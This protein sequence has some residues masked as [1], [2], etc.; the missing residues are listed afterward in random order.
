MLVIQAFPTQMI[1]G[2]LM[3]RTEVPTAAG[4][5]ASRLNAAVFG[6]LAG[7]GGLVHGI[8]EMLQGSVRPAGA[9]F[10]S[11][12]QGPI[13]THMDGEPAMSLIPNLFVTGFLTIL[14]SLAVIVWAG[15]FIHRKHGGRVLILLAVGMLLV[16]GGFGPPMI[17]ILAGWAGTGID[18]LSYA[19]QRR[20]SG[21]AGQVLARLWPWAFAVSVLAATLLTIGSLFLITLFDVNNAEFFSNLFLFVLLALLVTVP[22]GFAYDQKRREPQEPAP[23]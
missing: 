3:V 8:G 13:A 11:W 6:G 22:A 1:G 18:T 4:I 21:R 19:W 2:L 14:L 12:A 20:L 16:G 9:V 15:V 17:G 10:D 23:A 7:F 5:R